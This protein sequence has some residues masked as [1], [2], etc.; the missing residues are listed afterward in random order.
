LSNLQKIVLS[1]NFV[2]LGILLWPHVLFRLFNK[3]Y[4][5]SFTVSQEWVLEYT[6]KRKLENVNFL[7]TTDYKI[8][9]CFIILEAKFSVVKSKCV[10]VP[11]LPVTIFTLQAILHVLKSYSCAMARRE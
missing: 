1:K 2:A 11:T 8:W 3:V 7:D 6:I 9:F 5:R 10:L 4:F